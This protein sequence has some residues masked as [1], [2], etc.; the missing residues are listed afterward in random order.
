MFLPPVTAPKDRADIIA[1]LK[2][3]STSTVSDKPVTA[4][5]PKKKAAKK[6]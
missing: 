1:Y 2:T 4:E 6:A 5:K 3:Q